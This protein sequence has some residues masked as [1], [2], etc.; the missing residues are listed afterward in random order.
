MTSLPRAGVGPLLRQGR[1]LLRP[2]VL[3]AASRVLVLGSVALGALLH[4]DLGILDALG[5]WDGR[6]Y[7]DVAAHGYP[8]VVPQGESDVADAIAFFPLYPLLIRGLS[9]LTGLHEL[10]SAVALAAVF[11]TAAALALWALVE[12]VADREAADR[13]VALF[14]FFPGSFV[15]SLAYAEGLMLTLAI[16]CLLA[17][18]ARRWLAA[19]LAAAVATASRPNA[20]VLVAC[21][22]WAAVAAYRRDRDLRALAAPALA[23]L[24]L[25]GFFGYLWAHTGQPAAW[26]L[27]QRHG[28][29]ERVDFGYRTLREVAIAVR[30][31]ANAPV[32]VAVA[33]LAFVAVAAVLLWRWRPPA[34]LVVYAVGVIVL[35][36]LSRRLQARPRFILTAFPLIVAVARPLGGRLLAVAVAVSAALLSA[37][38][39]L[40]VAQQV[41]IVP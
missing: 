41:I 11:G 20:V 39:V 24:G 38:S 19:G 4:G 14:A 10:A 40:T 3:Y 7:T 21:C 25:L 16:T 27:V 23:P 37:L 15:L 17:L 28:W 1:V 13:A 30:D 8:T 36:L 29:G 9:T 33:G 35:A 18:L 2:L 34:E 31:P 12:R 6:W 26:L 22:A 32:V 5:V